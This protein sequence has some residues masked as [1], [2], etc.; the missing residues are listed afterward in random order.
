[1]E[2]KKGSFWNKDIDTQLDII[3][4]KINY[5]ETADTP[6]LGSGI[7]TGNWYASL[8]TVNG[9]LRL[10]G[11]LIHKV[12]VEH[13]GKKYYFDAKKIIDLLCEEVK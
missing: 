1:M 13:N 11:D 12:I 3:T 7:E 2:N 5:F 9:D 6:V 8:N 10:N 4:D